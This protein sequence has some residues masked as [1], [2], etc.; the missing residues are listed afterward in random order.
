MMNQ[1]LEEDSATNMFF[2]ENPYPRHQFTTKS[3][4]QIY[5]E[6]KS[7]DIVIH[8]C[9]RNFVWTNT[10]KQKFLTTISKKG[11]ISGPQF[12][13]NTD[14]ISEIMD[15]QNRIKTIIQFMDDKFQFEN[16]KGIKINYSQ[17]SNSQKRMFRNIQIG[18]TETSEWTTDEC[19]ENFCEIQEGMPLTAGEKINSSTTNP[20]TVACKQI[21][22][23]LGEFL[24]NPVKKCGLNL[25][26]NRYKH[27]EVLGTLMD[28]TIHNKFPQKE[29]KT[30]LDLFDTYKGDGN[31]D[32][33]NTAR[34]TV[35][36]VMTTYQTLVNAISELQKGANRSEHWESAVNVPHLLRSLHFVYK[37]RLYVSDVTDDIIL[38]FRNMI[39]KTHLIRTPES[40]RLW[41]DIK[42]MGQ[43]DSERI[44][45]KYLEFYNEL[46]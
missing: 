35:V 32:E 24:T 1:Q 19:E 10:Q 6:F 37:H 14:S 38:K 41:N 31:I 3:I 22:Q 36:Q 29:G 16:E 39:V 45:D 4:G 23:H 27:L 46:V 21:E 2:S 11:P 26:T 28:M 5:N 33:L 25:K 18:Y 20:V 8:P 40:K 42:V 13:K 17:L 7:G 9:Q 30:A 43:N 34:D 15:G 44:Y 12:N